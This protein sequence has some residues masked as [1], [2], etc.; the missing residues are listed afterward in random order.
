MSDLLRH[1]G[2]RLR[3]RRN[4]CGVT[5]AALARSAGVS[6]RFLVQLEAGEGN[7]SVGRLA[8]VC[9]ALGLPMAVLFRGIG[10]GGPNKTALVGL[11]G[12]GK[13]TVGARLAAALGAHFVELD[14][15]IEKAA[16]MSLR[17]I[18]EL[19][20]EAH[21]RTL[22][23]EVLEEVLRDPEP[24][25]IAAGGSIVTAQDTWRRLQDRARTVWLKASPGSH[26]ERVRAQ[27]D[28]RP[29]QGRPNAAAELEAILDERAGLYAEADI[30]LDTEGLGVDGVVEMLTRD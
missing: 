17:E 19:R 24:A 1:I 25:V 14:A 10:P 11:R 18:F 30:H 9:G 22:E 5:Q 15:L 26:L 2:T 8:D 20:G 4:A 3:A 7:I 29:M 6:P 12:A 27:G 28:L 16:G 23:R 21:Y 13:S